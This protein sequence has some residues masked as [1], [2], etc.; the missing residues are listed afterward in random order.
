MIQHYIVYKGDKI[1]IMWL[2]WTLEAV[3]DML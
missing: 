1:K 2:V 3:M